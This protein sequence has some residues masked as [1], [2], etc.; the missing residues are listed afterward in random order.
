MILFTRFFY[1][2]SLT[3]CNGNEHRVKGKKFA[4]LEL[5]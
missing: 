1:Y 3:F 5:V 4:I 2:S